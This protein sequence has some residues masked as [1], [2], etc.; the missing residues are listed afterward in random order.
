[1][2]DDKA[3]ADRA[4]D[5][6]SNDVLMMALD[7]IEREVIDAWESCPTRDKE[8][9]EELWRLYK[10]SKKFRGVLLG[11]VE[12]GKLQRLTEPSTFQKVTDFVK[13]KAA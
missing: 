9:K 12:A 8:G 6:L 2:M 4:A 3:R 13:G 1:M 10:T 5:L 11:Y 7:V